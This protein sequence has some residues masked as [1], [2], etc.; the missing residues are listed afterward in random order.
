MTEWL[1]PEYKGCFGVDHHPGTANK[2]SATDYPVPIIR[3]KLHRPRVT[4]DLIDRSALL[5]NRISGDNISLILVSA[6]A[7]YGK[8]TLISQWLDQHAGLSCWLSLDDADNNFMRFTTYLAAALRESLGDVCSQTLALLRS[9]T[10][11][12]WSELAGSICNELDE[13]DDPFI[14]ALDNYD[15]IHNS[16]IHSFVDAIL[17]HPP[18][19][20]RLVLM[21]RHD[22]PLS[23][24]LLRAR[25]TSC[26]IR[27]KDLRFSTQESTYLLTQASNGKLSEDLA[28]QLNQTI[29][30]WP[31]ALRLAILALTDH[32]NPE[33]L[34]RG[35]QGDMHQIS[36][37]LSAEIMANQSLAM[38]Q[39]LLKTSILNNF[40]ASL[41]DHIWSGE[42]TAEAESPELTGQS[43]IDQLQR[44]GLLTINLDDRQRWFRFHHLF[45]DMLQHQLSESSTP[46]LIADLH[47]RASTWYER[48]G[49]IEDAFQH[50]MQADGPSA[51][52][53]LMAPH[54]NAIANTERWSWVES[55]M[56]MIP[57]EIINQ[58][59]ELMALNAFLLQNRGFVAESSM[60]LDDIQQLLT[61]H[62]LNSPEHRTVKGTLDTVRAAQLGIQGHPEESLQLVHSA[63]ELLPQD[64][65]AVRGYAII[66]GVI[67]QCACG[68]LNHAQNIVSVALAEVP[69]L[70]AAPSYHARALLGLA[71]L[72]WWTADVSGA[73]LTGIEIA[74]L[75]KNYP[76][77]ESA[78]LGRYFAGAALY[79]QNN[80]EQA[81]E[82]LTPVVEDPAIHNV[83]F[84]MQCGFLLA[85]AHNAL[86][87][88]HWAKEI[89]EKVVERMQ[90]S[91]R[92]EMLIP[93][94][95]FEA[96]LA[97]RQGRLAHAAKWAQSF[98]PE[99]QL[100]FEMYSPHLSWV[101]QLLLTKNADLDK[102][103]IHLER[104]LD[105]TRNICS[106]RTLID[107][108][109]VKA[110]FL[111][112]QGDGD[113]AL[114]VLSE[115]LELALP[116][117]I[118]RTFVDLGQP[119][120]QLLNRVRAE[121]EILRFIGEILAVFRDSSGRVESTGPALQQSGLSPLSK[122][123]LEILHLLAARLS[124]REIAGQLFISVGTVKRHTANI[125]QKLSVEGRRPAVEKAIGIGL[126]ENRRSS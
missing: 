120:A 27:L 101:M 26:E 123:E 3:T 18:R 119:M 77:P 112:I 92:Q 81:V 36:G 74:E 125:Y 61:D 116:G 50:T 8:S 31:V 21:T 14:I 96:D 106:I 99:F 20:M 22:P 28:G 111:E 110:V 95:A 56:A 103:R 58:T 126:L 15:Q 40:C 41:C 71:F 37:Y 5:Q 78:T 108:L 93:A 55:W 39:R 12:H 102:A 23:L 67:A 57:Q 66:I 70:N 91:G 35:F 33:D 38:R 63:L 82:M 69:R 98:E 51:A 85:N 25:N 2:A 65:F 115:S 54:L 17:E 1:L 48:E 107:A 60:L 62:D 4:T 49:L 13:I 7:G 64:A 83:R 44:A 11:P 76:V 53:A 29:E 10:L 121:D 46:D 68:R 30:G 45:Q 114:T 6:P 34:I 100:V 73:K 84:Y 97:R 94:L 109:A 24:V 104:F 88:I 52:A 122:R 113:A 124:N 9:S 117:R 118:I 32:E 75:N 89:A 86:G 79:D 87:S 80:L 72:Q 43:F 16:E 59:P 105:H 19:N 47:R 90:Y 42:Q